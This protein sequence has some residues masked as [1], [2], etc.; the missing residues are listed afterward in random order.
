[1]SD[2]GTRSDRFDLARASHF[3]RAAGLQLTAIGPQRVAGYLGLGP[4]HHPLG[5]GAPFD[6]A[7]VERLLAR[8]EARIG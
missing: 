6:F 4:R 3:V 5:R 7:P 1:M 2:Q 8:R